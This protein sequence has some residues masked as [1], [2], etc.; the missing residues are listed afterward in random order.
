MRVR[1][2]C[3]VAEGNVADSVPSSLR[4][5]VYVGFYEVYIHNVALSRASLLFPIRT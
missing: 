1:K 4:F 3:C 5:V 2:G